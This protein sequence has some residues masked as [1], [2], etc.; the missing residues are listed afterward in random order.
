MLVE[1]LITQST[2]E[3]LDKAVLHRLARSPNHITTVKLTR[4]AN[5]SGSHP[6]SDAIA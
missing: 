5:T 3:A 6:G 1:A 4:H 2:V